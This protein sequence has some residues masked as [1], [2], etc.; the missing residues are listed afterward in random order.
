MKYIALA[1]VAAFADARKGSNFNVQRA[2]GTCE[3]MEPYE[4]RRLMGQDIDRNDGETSGRVWLSQRED[5][6]G[7]FENIKVW[8]HFDE[9]PEV[10]SVE[11]HLYSSADCMGAD[12]DAWDFQKDAGR[13]PGNVNIRG[14]NTQSD[15]TLLTLVDAG[16]SVGLVDGDGN[17][18]TCCNL[19]LKKRSEQN[20][21]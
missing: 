12:I 11:L 2:T 9:V 1:L 17:C 5:R 19:E 21:P 7:N 6:D 3:Y 16:A 14:E 10:D 15:P 13:R 18:L 20:R 8:G 4:G